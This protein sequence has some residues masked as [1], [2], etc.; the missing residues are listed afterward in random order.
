MDLYVILRRSGWPTGAELEKA[1]G[2]SRTVADEEMQDEVRWIRSYVLDE[3]DTSVGTVCVY[4]A[5][6]PE[7]VRKHAARAGLP[8]DEIIRV[9]DTV[10]V[11]AD[12]D[13]EAGRVAA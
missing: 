3:T 2:R 5:T 6:S 1:A 12:P 9:V 4:E 10:V 11:R 7:A 13:S 8:V